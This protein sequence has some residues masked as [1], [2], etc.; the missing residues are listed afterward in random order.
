MGKRDRASLPEPYM[1]LTC[2]LLKALKDKLG[3]RLIS[4]VVYGSVARG[5][6]KRDS[7]LDL[8]IV[9]RDLPKGR[10]KRQELF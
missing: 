3:D 9:A 7:D 8:L 4:L 2:K 6:A 10:L 5:E 1:R